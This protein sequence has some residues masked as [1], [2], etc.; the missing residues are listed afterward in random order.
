MKKINDRSLNNERK[1]SRYYIVLVPCVIVPGLSYLFFNFPI[2]PDSSVLKIVK[3]F[4]NV[5]NCLIIFSL[6]SLHA[7]VEQH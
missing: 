2:L 5:R 1:R 3:Y 4:I 6:F 7:R